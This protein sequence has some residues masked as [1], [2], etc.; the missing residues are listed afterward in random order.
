M[1]ADS[2]ADFA[3]SASAAATSEA[4]MADF[5][6]DFLFVLD[7]DDVEDDEGE[8]SNK[9]LADV[10]VVF[11]SGDES[12]EIRDVGRRLIGDTTFLSSVLGL[13]PL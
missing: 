11:P 12:G 8:D 7:E 3:K 5:S 1:A 9:D 2:A 13:L 10:G 6:I 4:L